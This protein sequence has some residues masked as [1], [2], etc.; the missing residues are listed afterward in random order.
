L[1]LCKVNQVQDI[2]Q[3][4]VTK[5]GTKDIVE[6]HLVLALQLIEEQQMFIANQTVHYQ[7]DLKRL[8]KV[9]KELSDQLDDFT[10]K[11]TLTINITYH[12]LTFIPASPFT[13]HNLGVMFAFLHVQS[14]SYIDQIRLLNNNRAYRRD[15]FRFYS[16]T[17]S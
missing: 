10:G 4:N 16:Y 12:S 15:F 7:K 9:I 17:E 14:L 5:I 2:N 6:N 11:V 3:E 13:S 8:E 1:K